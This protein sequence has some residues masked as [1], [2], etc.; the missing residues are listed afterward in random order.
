MISI[1]HQ[2]IR[3]ERV[4]D[5]NGH[6]NA[7]RKMLPYFAASGHN[8]YLKSPYIYL[9]TI[10]SKVTLMFTSNL[11]EVGKQFI[12][13]QSDKDVGQLE[14]DPCLSLDTL[15]YQKFTMK[16]LTGKSFVKVLTLHPTSDAAFFHSQRVY[17]Q[18]QI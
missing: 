4:G 15:R 3:A 5:W 2:F 9:Q 12:A 6:L 13:C 17:F 14:G 18:T 8:L 1:L 7:L 11:Q 10:C 16:V